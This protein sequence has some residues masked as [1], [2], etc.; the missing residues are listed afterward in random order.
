MNKLIIIALMLAGTCLFA[1]APEY[2]KGFVWSLRKDYRFPVTKL[3]PVCRDANGNKVWTFR[4]KDFFVQ[5][6]PQALKKVWDRRQPS[7]APELNTVRNIPPTEGYYAFTKFDV[8]PF[9][10][11]VIKCY[12]TDGDVMIDI[13]G[14][15]AAIIEWES[16]VSG[17]VEITGHLS[18]PPRQG[19]FMWALD[20]NKNELATGLIGDFSGG[21]G[22]K[23]LDK[24]KVKKGDHI[25]LTILAV[26]TVK[27]MNPGPTQLDLAIKLLEVAP[28]AKKKAEKK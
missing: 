26:T 24:V 2:K 5:G 18:K 27:H 14:T 1:A 22:S 19:H 16:P 3:P 15:R 4:M 21:E 13:L 25:Y 20:L 7:K 23:N 10:V 28:P 6:G 8:P 11:R 12:E 17:T 9:Y